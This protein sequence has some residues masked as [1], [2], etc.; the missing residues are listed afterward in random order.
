MFTE[1]FDAFTVGVILTCAA[2][3]WGIVIRRGLRGEL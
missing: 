3:C 1:P 2:W